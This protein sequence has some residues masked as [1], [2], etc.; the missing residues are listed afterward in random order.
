MLQLSLADEIP[1]SLRYAFA[2]DGPGDEPPPGPDD[3]GIP[4]GEIRRTIERLQ[5]EDD[6]LREDLR[7]GAKGTPMCTAKGAA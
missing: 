1:E 2:V 4:D 3:R 5:R 7:D 6:E